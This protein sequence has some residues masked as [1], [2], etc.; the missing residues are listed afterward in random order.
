M[1]SSLLCFPCLDSSSSLE[2][3]WP[4]KL[5]YVEVS[6]EFPEPYDLH[7]LVEGGTSAIFL[8]YSDTWEINSKKN[9][10][11]WDKWLTKEQEWILEQ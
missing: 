2:G 9:S 7:Q 1:E 11:Q 6:Y 4:Q 10:H 8:L 3:C 5:R